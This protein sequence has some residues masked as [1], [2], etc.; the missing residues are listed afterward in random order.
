MLLLRVSLEVKGIISMVNP[1]DNLNKLLI[2][3]SPET[4]VMLWGCG[5]LINLYHE[6][7]Q[8]SLFVLNTL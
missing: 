4:R 6:L 8:T 1:L 7:S 5:F 2:N 3:L